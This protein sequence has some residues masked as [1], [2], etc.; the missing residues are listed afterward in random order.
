MDDLV[1]IVLP[2]FNGEKYIASA[3]NSVL[4]QSYE[5]WELIIVNDCS[6]DDTAKII[7]EFVERDNRIKIFNN[8]NNLRLPKSLNFGFSKTKGQYLTWVSDDNV[9]EPFFISKMVAEIKNKKCDFVYSNYYQINSEDEVIRK[10]HVLDKEYILDSNVVG[11]SFMYTREVYNKVGEYDEQLFLMEDYDYWIRVCMHFDICKINDFLYK[12]RVHSLSLTSR[13]YYEIMCVTI[14]YML[15]NYERNR[16]KFS[17][18]KVN[19]GLAGAAYNCF[20][21]KSFKLFLEVLYF[22]I[23]KDAIG[24]LIGFFYKLESKKNNSNGRGNE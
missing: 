16:K 19:R 8:E 6:T 1:S 3:I 12:Y 23:R 22:G 13:R 5:N 20:R 9:L 14:Q 18:K 21:I 11:A 17:R 4:A 24:F 2:T 15:E 7:L 10:I